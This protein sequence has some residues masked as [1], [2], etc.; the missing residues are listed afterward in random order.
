RPESSV[1]VSIFSQMSVTGISA[2]ISWPVN[3][4]RH[5]S[6]FIVIQ[7]SVISANESFRPMSLL[8]DVQGLTRA[9]SLWLDRR[10]CGQQ[11]LQIHSGS[12]RH[13]SHRFA[14]FYNV[15]ARP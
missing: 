3:S 1:E 13:F 10:I 7:N 11:L 15:G 2:P 8:R 14:R 5:K 6:A 12:T 9:Q 4:A